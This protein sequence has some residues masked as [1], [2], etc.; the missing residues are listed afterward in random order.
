MIYSS[1]ELRN[2]FKDI[3]W[4]MK[5]NRLEAIV[6]PGTQKIMY[7]ENYGPQDGFFIEGWRALHFPKTSSIVE[8]SYREGGSTI[9]IIKS[10]K[11]KLKLIPS[12]SPIGIEECRI[13]KNTVEITF[14]GL[15]GGGVS[16]SYSRGMAEGVTK[17]EVINDGGGTKLGKAKIILPK[18]RL[19]LIGVDDTDNNIE[20][21]TYSLVHNI[22]TMVS[23]KLSV[24]YAIHVNVQLYPYNPTKTKNCFST[25]VGIIFSTN[26]EKTKIINLF[27]KKLKSASLS[28]ETGMVIYE[29][30]TFKKEFIKICE[31]AKYKFIDNVDTL[32][33]SAIKNGVIVKEV[34]GKRGLIGAISSLVFFDRPDFAVSLP[35]NKQ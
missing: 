2:K 34:T 13:K 35:L 8:K 11:A 9:C 26:A 27:E 6:D 12:F 3:P 19:L 16:A 21:A 14:A 7:I 31:S 17:V 24:R 20:G 1:K 4:V 32:I 23:I 10:G 22:A 25:V 5:Y 33:K 15:G 29:G 28:K 18:K 30:F